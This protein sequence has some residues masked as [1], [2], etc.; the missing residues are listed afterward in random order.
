MSTGMSCAVRSRMPRVAASNPVAPTRIGTPAAAQAR[1]LAA[2]LPA[3]LKSTAT[4]EA[5]RLNVGSAVIV[6]PVGSPSS[7]ASRP[8]RELVEEA[9]APQRLNA[10]S[11]PCASRSA[12]TRDC[13]MRP[14]IPNT[15]SPGMTSVDRPGKELLDALEEGLFAR[16]MAA[17]PQRGL[18]FLEQLFLVGS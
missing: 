13:H 12:R 1:A 10:P 4:A 7:A 14:V 8:N 3:K 2:T 15:T 9:T 6:I 18:E 5:L 17:L 16:L 11:A